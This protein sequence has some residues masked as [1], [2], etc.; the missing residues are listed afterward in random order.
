MPDERGRKDHKNIARRGSPQTDAPTY[1][2]M[3][4][5][6]RFLLLGTETA[7]LLSDYV[8]QL[9][10]DLRRYGFHLHKLQPF[11]NGRITVEFVNRKGVK[12]VPTA[13]CWYYAKGSRKW[14]YN[15]LKLARLPLRNKRS[16]SFYDT[17]KTVSAIL[18]RVQELI[19]LR[20]AVVKRFNDYRDAIKQTVEYRGPMLTELGQ[21]LDWYDREHATLVDHPTESDQW[22]ADDDSTVE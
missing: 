3:T 2:Q 8:L 22:A 10:A 11:H 19:G 17:A 12:K 20:A 6:N 13:G 16:G 1:S 9:D 5:S 14:L 18:T 4:E 15:E 7:E 21:E